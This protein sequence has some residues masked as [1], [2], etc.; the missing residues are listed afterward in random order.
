MDTCINDTTHLNTLIYPDPDK[1]PLEP[2][3]VV[4]ITHCCIVLR[5]CYINALKYM[6]NENSNW[7]KVIK[8]SLEQLKDVGFV[9]Y[10]NYVSVMRLHRYF[11]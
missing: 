3:Q 8:K 4:Y 7:E 9:V 1:Y 11:H 6:N 10:K 2:H 5:C